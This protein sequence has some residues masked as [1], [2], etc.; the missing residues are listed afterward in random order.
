[1]DVVAPAVRSRMMSGIRGKNTL[2]ELAVRSAAH[3]LGLRFRLHRRDL[4]GKPDLVFPKYW[5]VL[6]VHGCFWHRHGCGLAATPKTRPEFWAT[7]FDDNVKRDARN[8]GLL[9]ALGWRVVEIWEC[10]TRNQGQ[11]TGRLRNVFFGEA[12]PE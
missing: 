2:P 11:L 4:P 9:E 8:R 5:T 3:R 7:K 10:E 1:M 12:D 6:F